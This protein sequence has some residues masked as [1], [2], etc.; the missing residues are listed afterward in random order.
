MT[1]LQWFPIYYA[2]CD[3]LII[4]IRFLITEVLDELNKQIKKMIVTQTILI[5]TT[6][7]NNSSSSK[8]KKEIKKELTLLGISSLVL[9]SNEIEAIY[10]RSR[11]IK[12]IKIEKWSRATWYKPAQNR[13]ISY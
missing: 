1:I 12:Y 10:N 9:F 5:T 13:F 11:W 4:K 6:N 3:F 8:N 7:T 2:S